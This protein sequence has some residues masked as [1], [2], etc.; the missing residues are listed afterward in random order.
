MASVELGEVV[1]DRFWEIIRGANGEAGELKRILWA[2][3]E[4]EIALFHEEF[5]RTASV[6]QGEPFD[7]LMGEDVSE[8][9]LMDIA[10]WVVAQGRDFYEDILKHPEKMPQEVDENDPAIMNHVT[11]VVF[12]E[13]FGK[14]LDFF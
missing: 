6:L 9:G 2:M 13:K 4:A 14:R 8:D 12:R 1:S 11:S 5:V 3:T 10:Y 7:G